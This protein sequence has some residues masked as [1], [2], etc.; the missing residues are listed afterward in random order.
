MA[1]EHVE[2]GELVEIAQALALAIMRWC[3]VAKDFTRER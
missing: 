3:G 2:I 1:D